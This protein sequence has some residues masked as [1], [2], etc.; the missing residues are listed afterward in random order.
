MRSEICKNLQGKF[1][2]VKSINKFGRKLNNY[3]N[4]SETIHQY[5]DLNNYEV[6]NIML[7]SKTYDNSI[8]VGYIF[9]GVVILLI[10]YFSIT[11]TKFS[12]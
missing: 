4:L 7:E 6:L 3:L 8:T 11:F 12:S 1:Y 2:D 5:I 9:G 10:G